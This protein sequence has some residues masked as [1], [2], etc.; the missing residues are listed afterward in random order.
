[1]DFDP[2]MRRGLTGLAHCVDYYESDDL[3]TP[4]ELVTSLIAWYKAMVSHEY[5]SFNVIMK[6]S[7]LSERNPSLLQ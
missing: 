5:L 6:F 4:Q 2:Y 1:M 3:F 7:L